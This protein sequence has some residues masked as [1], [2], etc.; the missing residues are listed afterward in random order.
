MATRE[1]R[2]AW[3]RMTTDRAIDID[4]L[5]RAAHL[6]VEPRGE[7]WI[8]T[9]GA[10]PHVVR[11]DGTVCDCLDAIALRGGR[12]KHRLAVAL[13]MGLDGELLA[14]LRVLVPEPHR[15]RRFTREAMASHA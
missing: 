3:A 15:Q 12:C 10:A 9:G 5:A 6:H 4:R 1:R 8:V 13:A 14:G 11:E 7:S 2:R